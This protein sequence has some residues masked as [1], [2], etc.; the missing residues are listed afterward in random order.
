MTVLGD[1]NADRA[2]LFGPLLAVGA[3]PLQRRAVQRHHRRG[4]RLREQG[5][6]FGHVAGLE[7][8]LEIAPIFVERHR[9]RRDELRAV[10]QRDP[11]HQAVRAFGECRENDD[12]RV[13]VA[14][15]I[16]ASQA[17]DDGGDLLLEPG[18]V[19]VAQIAVAGDADHQREAVG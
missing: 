14:M 2:V 11:R 15:E 16:V 10:R 18:Y 1:E 17:G 4:Q 6:E 8:R 19:L 5:V 7:P 13:V 12:R 3:Q 9:Q